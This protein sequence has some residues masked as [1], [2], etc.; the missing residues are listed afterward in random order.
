[1]QRLGEERFFQTEGKTFVKAQGPRV[2]SSQDSEISAPVKSAQ[3]A[4]V[5]GGAE[6]EPGEGSAARAERVLETSVR[7]F[8]F[9]LRAMRWKPDPSGHM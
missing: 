2:Q 5:G 9:V 3:P 6:G 8:D 1:M 7:S 4:G